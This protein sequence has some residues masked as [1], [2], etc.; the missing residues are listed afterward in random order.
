MHIDSSGEGPPL[1]LIHSLLTDARAYDAVAATLSGRYRL[2]R[3]WLPGFGPSPPLTP[4]G[5]P[6]LFHLAAMVSEAMSETGVEPDAAVLGNGLGAF[7]AVAMAIAHGSDF[8]PL[9]VANGGAVFSED[10]RG[11]FSTMSR[12]VS[13]AGMAAVVE[14][15]VRRIF[16]EEYLAAH[17]EAIEDR[18]RALLEVDPASFASCC[19]ALHAMDLRPGLGSITNPT[20][21]IGGSA[22]ATTPPEMSAELAAS[23]AGAELV[24]LDDCGHCPPLQQP[25]ALAAA[26]D[27]FLTR[28]LP[29]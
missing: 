4:D 10:R 20:L 9:I 25:A 22:D 18:R 3:A 12:L 6:D 1:V 8:G 2:H 11:A 28:H 21:V 24:V 26:V 5:S 15:A 27:A 23:I 14:T 29:R 7:I 17:P 13:E 16:P 19:R